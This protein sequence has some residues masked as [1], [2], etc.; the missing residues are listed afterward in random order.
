MLESASTVTD[1][2][3]KAGVA[4]NVTKTM[5]AAALATVSKIH[6]LVVLSSLG[7]TRGSKATPKMPTEYI[8][9]LDPRVKPKD[10][11]GENRDF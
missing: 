7:L 3:A 6:F 4:Q 2:K 5:K 10:D 8:A 9:A 11:K 1:G